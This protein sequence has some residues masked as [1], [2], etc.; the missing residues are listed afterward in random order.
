MVSVKGLA[1]HLGVSAKTIYKMVENGSIPYLRVGVGRGTLR[2][3]VEDVERTLKQ[4]TAKA[5]IPLE[6]VRSRHL[7]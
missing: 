3:D 6:Q 7:S 4:R 5:T 2:F 1:K